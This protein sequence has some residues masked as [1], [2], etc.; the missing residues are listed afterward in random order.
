[1]HSAPPL[2]Y[3]FREYAGLSSLLCA[4]CVQSWGNGSTLRF[5]TMLHEDIYMEQCRHIMSIRP[6]FSPTHSLF[7]FASFVF[8]EIHAFRDKARHRLASLRAPDIFGYPTF[9]YS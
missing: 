2:W 7:V 3:L 6:H 1:M 9:R 8:H 5:L 4:Q